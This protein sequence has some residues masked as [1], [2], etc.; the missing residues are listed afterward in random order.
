M[1][2]NLLLFSLGIETLT[3]LFS[4]AG[5]FGKCLWDFKGMMLENQNPPAHSVWGARLLPKS[6]GRWTGHL[7][8]DSDVVLRHGRVGS[9]MLI[10]W[11]SIHYHNPQFGLQN[12]IA[13]CIWPFPSE[14]SAPASG[15][16]D[17]WWPVTA[18]R[19]RELREGVRARSLGN[20]H[21]QLL[22]L[23]QHWMPAFFQ[24]LQGRKDLIEFSNSYC[25]SRGWPRV[26]TLALLRWCLAP[27]FWF[28]SS[29]IICLILAVPLPLFPPPLLPVCTQPASTHHHCALP[30]SSC[31][32]RGSMWC[33]INTFLFQT[34]WVY[35]N[36]PG[37][38]SSLSTLFSTECKANNILS[39]RSI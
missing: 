21:S 16:G 13:E 15:V 11:Y 8:K 23:Q 10:F 18:L 39:R 22:M 2:F 26:W 19:L 20:T 35:F 9:K 6:S 33:Q 34:A 1:M 12:A 36:L 38:F 3:W 28:P 29:C 32:I 5:Q 37:P 24:M 14:E 17:E 4:R 7:Q 27:C 30:C 31:L 25:P